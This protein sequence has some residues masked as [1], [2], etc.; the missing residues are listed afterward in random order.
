MF[1]ISWTELLVIAAVA[2]I[3]I[4]PKDLPRALRTLGAW[5]AKVQS[6][7]REFQQQFNEAVREVELDSIKKEVDDLSR[8][9]PV[10][11]LKEPSAAEPKVRKGE[12]PSVAEDQGAG[13]ARP[14][15]TL[16]AERIWRRRAWPE[17][18][19]GNDM[20]ETGG[21]EDSLFRGCVCPSKDVRHSILRTARQPSSRV[22][23]QAPERRAVGS[24]IA[25]TNRPLC[26]YP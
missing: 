24:M 20:N 3:V 21:S 7:A 11:A 18:A 15:P 16:T 5:L 8:T 13:L 17:P 2:L 25:M 23:E 22:M 12:K 19:M 4:G 10:V 9:D 14:G 1:D 6:M 26:S